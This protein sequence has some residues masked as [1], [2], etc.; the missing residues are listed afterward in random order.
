MRHFSFDKASLQVDA[1]MSDFQPLMPQK[2]KVGR[3][4]LVRA[5]LN[6]AQ[7]RVLQR[8]AE[9]RAI[10]PVELVTRIVATVLDDNMVNA[11][12]DDDNKGHPNAAA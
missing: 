1:P 4:L 10:S 11:V 12:L 7:F 3:P 2:R 5:R 8:Q 6:A 9:H